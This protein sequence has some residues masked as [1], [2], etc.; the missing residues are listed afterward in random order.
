MRASLHDGFANL[1]TAST[2]R[3]R[4]LSRKLGE[5]QGQRPGGA[6]AGALAGRHSEFL[7]SWSW[8]SSGVA[9][10]TGII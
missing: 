3:I 9:V 5:D 10:A 8:S 1:D 6:S 7:G 4:R 2:R